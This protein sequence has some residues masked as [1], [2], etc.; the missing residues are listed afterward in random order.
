MGK[1]KKTYGT[2]TAHIVRDAYSERCKFNVH[3]HSYSWEVEISGNLKEN[4]MVLDFGELKPIKEF[5]DKF[6]HAMILWEKEREDFKQFFFDNCKR[7]IVMKKNT[8]AENMARLLNKFVSEWLISI[9][10]KAIVFQINVWET[11]SGCASSFCNDFDDDDVC[12]YIH[13]DK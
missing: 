1:I 10:S 9:K 8:T 4:G 2:E 6:D 7:V 13:I 11:K 5:V 3:G 12:V